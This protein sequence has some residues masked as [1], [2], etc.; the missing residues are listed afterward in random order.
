MLVAPRV[1][2]E[3]A[4]AQREQHEQPG[5]ERGLHDDQRREQQRED[6]QRP[7]EHREGGPRQ[8]ARAPQQPGDERRAQVHIARRLLRVHR[9][10]GDPYA[11]QARRSHRRRDSQHEID[12]V[13]PR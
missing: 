1:L 7:A 3:H 11:V 6:L 9:L 2:A 10:E 5:R 13:R 4:L 8:P 12:H